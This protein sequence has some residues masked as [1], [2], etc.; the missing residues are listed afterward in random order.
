MDYIEYLANVICRN[1]GLND[2]YPDNQEIKSK[3]IFNYG[4]KNGE[5]R[6]TKADFFETNVINYSHEGGDGFDL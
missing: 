3:W 5:H 6:A 4:E 2:V 1:A